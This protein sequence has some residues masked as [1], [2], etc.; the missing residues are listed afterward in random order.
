MSA[1]GNLSANLASGV[2][3]QAFQTTTNTAIGNFNQQAA[4]AKSNIDTDSAFSDLFSSSMGL[5]EKWDNYQ[6]TPAVG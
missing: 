4:N 3:N 2:A 6:K 5:D 1:L